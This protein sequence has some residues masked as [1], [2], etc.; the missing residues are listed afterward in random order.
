MMKQTADARPPKACMRFIA[1]L[2]DL[3]S[4][5]SIP[6]HMARRFPR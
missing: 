1:P 4:C 5:F 2:F 6:R 3:N